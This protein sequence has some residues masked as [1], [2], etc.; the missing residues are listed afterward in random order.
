M[1]RRR[2]REA[3][4]LI[5]IRLLTQHSSPPQCTAAA[6]GPSLGGH[7]SSVRPDSWVAGRR[8][9]GSSSGAALADQSPSDCRTVQ[10][11]TPLA[12]PFQSLCNCATAESVDRR[13]RRTATLIRKM[14]E[15]GESAA[16]GCC[17][18]GV[19]G[20]GGGVPFGGAE[21]GKVTPGK[22]VCHSTITCETQLK[23]R[24]NN[25]R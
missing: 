7:S 13:L 16:A 23:T 17:C 6:S 24:G 10:V 19:G 15:A 9:N 18:W 3:F 12:P 2:P 4:R 25:E 14:T 5:C 22:S 8:A 20:G 11:W 21:R 1:M